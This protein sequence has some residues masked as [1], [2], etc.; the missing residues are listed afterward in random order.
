METCNSSFLFYHEN[1]RIIPLN[2]FSIISHDY[3]F[4]I[5]LRRRHIFRN[6][7]I[8]CQNE[9]V[10]DKHDLTVAEM[11]FTSTVLSQQDQK[12]VPWKMSRHLTAAAFRTVCPLTAKGGPFQER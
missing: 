1:E 7:L 4:P 5:S 10:S 12:P 2:T 6:H 8:F 3:E 11:L 9:D